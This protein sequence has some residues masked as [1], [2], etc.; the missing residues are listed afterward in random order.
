[1]K[2]PHRTRAA[3]IFFVGEQ[4]NH[5]P[6]PSHDLHVRPAPPQ[7]RRGGTNES[8]QGAGRH[9]NP[10]SATGVRSS[11]RLRATAGPDDVGGMDVS[12]TRRRR[13]N[14]RPYFFWGDPGNLPPF[15]EEKSTLLTVPPHRRRMMQSSPWQNLVSV[16]SMLDSNTYGA[17]TRSQSRKGRSRPTTPKV[18]GTPKVKRTPRVRRTPEVNNQSPASTTPEV[19]RTP[20]VRRTPPSPTSSLGS[21]GYPPIDHFSRLKSPE[22]PV[23]LNIP[24]LESL[25]YSPPTSPRKSLPIYEI[26]SPDFHNDFPL[27]PTPENDQSPASTSS[28]SPTLSFL[29]EQP[30]S[31]S[32]F[33]PLPPTPDDETD[34]ETQDEGYMNYMAMATQGIE[35]MQRSMPDQK[36]NSNPSQI[37]V[38]QD[39]GESKNMSQELEVLK[40]LDNLLVRD[41]V[42]NDVKLQVTKFFVNNKIKL[43]HNALD[44]QRKRPIGGNRSDIAEADEFIAITIKNIPKLTREEIVKHVLG[45]RDYDKKH[46]IDL[47]TRVIRRRSL[48]ETVEL[49]NWVHLADVLRIKKTVAKPSPSPPTR[50]KNTARYL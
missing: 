41:D 6:P 29:N 32:S 34:D 23:R 13:V 18:K 10:A 31:P 30:L 46:V 22:K 28:L 45:T 39:E 36:S 50:K 47:L 12:E 8:Q 40:R 38:Y 35:Y 27:P 20:R 17:V 11:P 48:Q 44:Y 14:D 42:S 4:T 1:M 2:S 25:P 16:C 5:N 7:R 21:T 15:S 3:G 43:L 9:E 19:K 24:W 37:V 33:V 49:P 26:E